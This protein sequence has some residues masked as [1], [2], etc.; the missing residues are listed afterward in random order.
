MTIVFTAPRYHTNQHYWVKTLQDAGH[1][2][3]FLVLSR[4]GLEVTSRLEPQELPLSRLYCLLRRLL[5]WLNDK[6][7]GWSPARR[8]RRALAELQPDVVIIRDPA[9]PMSLA[10]IRAAR[11]LGL[12]IVLY[13]QRP[14]HQLP[15]DW[16]L[17]ILMRLQRRAGRPGI[18]PMITP[19][20]GE[21]D[22]PHYI[23][24]GW[25]YLPFVMEPDPAPDYRT[26]KWC[27]EGVRRVVMVAKYLP[28]KNHLLLVQALEELSSRY[29]VRLEIIGGHDTPEYQQV[30]AQVRDYISERG[31]DWVTQTEPMPY[32]QLQQRLHHYDLYVLPSR[33][34][35]VGVS[36]L[37]AM[38]K[39]LPVVCSTTAGARNYVEHGGNGRI[40]AS[41]SLADLTEQ[42][43]AIL[44]DPAQLP[45]MG[46]RSLQLV[47]TAFSPQS[48]LDRFRHIIHG[49]PIATRG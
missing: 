22:A 1:R 29:P 45:R 24:P 10:A 21:V 34:E 33:N 14:Q 16:K 40:F 17:R 46:A 41:D 47:E 25:E 43:H 44:Q 49:E 3:E 42:L 4:Q 9:L 12:P 31:L 26:R 30:F 28:R 8:V 39:G 38:G 23:P 18:A 27:P 15:G 35:A 48:F 2:V 32:A 20:R 13:T 5:P 6:K 19:V 37:E 7:H 36:L 11:R